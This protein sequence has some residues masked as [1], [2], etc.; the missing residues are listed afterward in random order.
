[1]N[2]LFALRK[3]RAALIYQSV[4]NIEWVRN[5]KNTAV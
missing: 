3:A 5:E 2:G 1:M 4:Q